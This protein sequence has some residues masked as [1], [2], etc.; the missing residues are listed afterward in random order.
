MNIVHLLASPFVGGPERQVLG[1][2][3]AM[4][5][6]TTFLSFAERGLAR[7]FLDKARADGFDAHELHENYPR[8]GAAI[9]EIAG[10]LKRL[11]AD[12]LLTSGYKPDILGWRAARTAG[13][14]VVGIAH[15]WTGV[16]LKVKLYEWL[17][18]LALAWMDACVCVSEATA[19]RARRSGIR[20]AVV[21]RNAIDATPYDTPAPDARDAVRAL[22]PT[23]PRLVVGAAGRLSPEKGF[24][25]LIAAAALVCRTRDVGF[26][27][28]GK[29]PREDDL[30]RQI[31]RLGLEGRVVLG[32]FRGDLER[33]LPGLDIAALSSHTEGLPVAV[34]EAQAAGVPVVATAAGG[35]PEVI[36]EGRTGLLVPPNDPASLAHKLGE[37]L[38]DPARR[39][40]MGA[41]G[42][43]RVR[44]E[45]TFAAQAEKFERL[46]GRVVPVREGVT[47]VPG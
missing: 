29:G 30:R 31:T 45:F 22:F 35:T 7:P 44:E 40:A 26:V 3:R 21:I 18:T 38:D 9:A 46:L 2:A 47:H 16:T 5:H 19:R 23:P 28:F 11:R 1:L 6:R 24:D 13:A 33:V 32:G 14:P 20:K 25:V 15:G 36:D 12:V 42:W 27:I 43:R 8:V 39:K 41:V 34:L 10:W 37:L 17:D 4:P